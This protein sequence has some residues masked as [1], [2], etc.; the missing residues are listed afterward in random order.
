[1][2]E[3]KPTPDGPSEDFF[4]VGNAA[5]W[6]LLFSLISGR[7]IKPDAHS[8]EE[9]E[10]LKSMGLRTEDWK[11]GKEEMKKWTGKAVWKMVMADDV[12]E[13]EGRIIERDEMTQA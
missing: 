2:T 7:S 4:T 11:G 9:V 5:K 12:D 1:V 13:G 3:V 8:D 10:L 6:L